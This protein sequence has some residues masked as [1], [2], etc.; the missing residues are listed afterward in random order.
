PDP[1]VVAGAFT[2]L[3]QAMLADPGRLIEAQ[4]RWWQQM[5][6][7]WQT[8]MRKALGEP[9]APVAA[10]DPADKRF[11]DEAWNEALVFDYVKQS[12]LVSARC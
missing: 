2:K 10:P 11:K 1:R 6:E 8:Q 9:V 3:T 7:L 12:Y 4:A 5:G